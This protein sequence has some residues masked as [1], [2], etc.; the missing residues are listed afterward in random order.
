MAFYNTIVFMGMEI[1][2][3]GVCELSTCYV[4]TSTMIEIAGNERLRFLQCLINA[5]NLILFNMRG[6]QLIRTW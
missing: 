3:R 6:Y 1:L 2:N 4:I 5:L